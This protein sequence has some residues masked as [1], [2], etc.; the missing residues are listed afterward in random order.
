VQVTLYKSGDG[1]MR[2]DTMINA[3]TAQAEGSVCLKLDFQL[4]KAFLF[5]LLVTDSRPSNS[6]GEYH[7]ATT[8]GLPSTSTPNPV[9]GSS[10]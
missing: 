6:K 2:T 1:S 5:V 4:Y 7:R 10:Y 3:K 8:T 9:Q